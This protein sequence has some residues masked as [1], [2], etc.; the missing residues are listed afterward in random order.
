MR[1]VHERLYARMCVFM[2]MHVLVFVQASI[3]VRTH[4][5]THTHT[6]DGRPGGFGGDGLDSG[7]VAEVS[8]ASVASAN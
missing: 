7:G 5:P 8:A 6:P 3:I 4:T 2:D 1:I